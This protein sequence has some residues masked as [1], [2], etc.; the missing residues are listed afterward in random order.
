M[1]KKKHLSLFTI[2]EKPR[3]YPDEWVVREWK[4]I[5]GEAVPTKGCERAATLEEAR[6]AIPSGLV[7]IAL[8]ESDDPVI[9]ET[10][11]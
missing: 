1:K 3:D 7:C 11:L 4:I 10:W 5:K 8:S 9:V 6:R 2:Y